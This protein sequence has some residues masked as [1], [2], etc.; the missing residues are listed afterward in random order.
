MDFD[1]SDEQRQLKDSVERLL[2]AKYADLKLRDAARRPNRRAMRAGDLGAVCR[3]WPAGHPVRRGARRPRRRAV[4][5]MLVM[6]AIGRIAGDRALSRDGRARRRRRCGMAA[7]RRSKQRSFR[8][9]STAAD[10]GARAPGTAVAL[11]SA[12]VGDHGESRRQG[13]LHARRR[14]VGRAHG[15]SADKLIVSARTGGGRRDASGIGLFLVDGKA[16]GVTRR[17]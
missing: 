3:A 13:R 5:T 6:E 12:D 4:E 17:G 9:S 7:T 14:E 15:D 11:R 2:A 1:L 8:T 16:P 10:A